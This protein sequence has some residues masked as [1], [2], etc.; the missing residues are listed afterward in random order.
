MSRE[1]WLLKPH[2]LLCAE[3]QVWTSVLT[4]VIIIDYFTN[5]EKECIL[6]NKHRST[7]LQLFDNIC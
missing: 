6:Q 5:L 1:G 4:Q 2:P 7:S 3:L